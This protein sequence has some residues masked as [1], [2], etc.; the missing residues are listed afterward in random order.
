MRWSPR[1]DRLVLNEIV[2]P[3]FGSAALFTGLI[4][5]GGELVRFTEYLQGGQGLALVGRLLL[6]TLPGILSL[7]FPMAMLLA[8]LLGLGRLSSD[9]ELVAVVATG[10]RFERVMIPVVVFGLAISLVGIYFNQTI[11]PN[12][13]RSR[14][15]IIDG[16]KDG[17]AGISSA[18]AF[19]F[20][21]RDEKG[22]LTLIHVDGGVDLASDTLRGVSVQAWKNGQMESAIGAPSAKWKRG[23]KNWTFTN[24][25]LADFSNPDAP[26]VSQGASGQTREVELGTPESLLVQSRPVIEV[27][28]EGLKKRAQVLRDGGENSGAREAEV[29][30]ARRV[31]LPLASLA[32]AL[33]GAPLGVRPQRAGKGV[34]FGLSVVITF[35]YWMSVQV[36]STIG[37][38]GFLPPDI[39]LALPNLVCALLGMY[40]IRRVLR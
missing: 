9:G 34:G 17:G 31:E 13:N 36:A 26:L 39:A 5:A 20:P 14:Q 22:N 27:T 37:K 8:T 40:L 21:Q 25:R 18:N 30:L 23:T 33:I 29:E 24:Y 3:F 38:G 32:F 2:G 16:L 19:T 12:A 4:F 6:L 35:V 11:V 1:L 10:T 15:A 28:S 7:T